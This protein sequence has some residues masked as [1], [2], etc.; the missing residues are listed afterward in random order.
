MSKCVES[1]VKV[2]RQPGNLEW[3]R[4]EGLVYRLPLDDYGEVVVVCHK[5]HTC[6]TLAE[7]LKCSAAPPFPHQ[8]PSIPPPYPLPSRRM[9][10]SVPFWHS[11]ATVQ[12]PKGH[13]E[14]V[15][16]AR[17]RRGVLRRHCA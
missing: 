10:P 12:G 2:P 7:P 16:S 5:W 17:Q 8:S 14:R 1:A 9:I 13:R 15:D 6:G 3:Q 11:F 4:E